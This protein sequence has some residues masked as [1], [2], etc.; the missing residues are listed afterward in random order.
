M[1]GRCLTF[2]A[3]RLLKP[4]T[5]RLTMAPA[6]ADA[7]HEAASASTAARVRNNVALAWTLTLAALGDLRLDVQATCNGQTIRAVWLPALGWNYGFVLVLLALLGIP[8][9]GMTADGELRFSALL[10]VYVIVMFPNVIAPAAFILARREHA[11]ARP[12]VAAILCVTVVRVL[13]TPLRGFLMNEPATLGLS[14]FVAILQIV[15]VLA[16]LG[17]TLSYGR[18]WGVAARLAAILVG[19]V[20]L[21]NALNAYVGRSPVWAYPALFVVILISLR[22]RRT[23][24]PPPERS[25][26]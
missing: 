7:Q 16:M 8:A 20:L 14:L 26:A 13:A 11:V 22:I 15:V 17:L 25:L 23:R 1:T 19:S 3:E 2:V 9:G 21:V 18:G 10:G 5:L 4:E 24:T 12:L 6:I